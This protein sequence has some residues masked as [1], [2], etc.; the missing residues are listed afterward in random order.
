MNS[1]DAQELFTTQLPLFALVNAVASNPNTENVDGDRNL[2]VYDP[3][4]GNHGFVEL[5]LM[6]P[7]SFSIAFPLLS[8]IRTIVTGTLVRVK[9]P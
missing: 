9:T 4:S 3:L 2:M 8:A 5:L 1:F 7:I 6:K